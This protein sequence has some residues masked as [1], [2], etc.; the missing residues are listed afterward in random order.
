[1]SGEHNGVVSMGGKIF[2]RVDRPTVRIEDRYAYV[3]WFREMQKGDQSGSETQYLFPL[4]WIDHCY[5]FREDPDH[6]LVIFVGPESRWPGLGGPMV[7]ND[8]T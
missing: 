6:L 8:T 7:Q 5:L 1:M 2:A 4:C 3:Q